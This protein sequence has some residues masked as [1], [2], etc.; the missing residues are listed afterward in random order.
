MAI[1]I[2]QGNLHSAIVLQVAPIIITAEV[3][4]K[5]HVSAQRQNHITYQAPRPCL[6]LV[7]SAMGDT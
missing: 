5:I 3:F 1:A 4:N 2:L 7:P 6:A